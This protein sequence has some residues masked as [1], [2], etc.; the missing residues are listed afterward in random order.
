MVL[1]NGWP[2]ASGGDHNVTRNV[3]IT[4]DAARAP[5]GLSG[6]VAEPTRYQAVDGTDGTL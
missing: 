6:G 1:Q 5:Q 3:A 2:I 4:T